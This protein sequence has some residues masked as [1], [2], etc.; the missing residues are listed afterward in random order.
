M[1]GLLILVGEVVRGS[2]L[3]GNSAETKTGSNAAGSS[4]KVNGSAARRSLG[5]GRTSGEAR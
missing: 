4:R 1:I 2:V 5:L 3:P